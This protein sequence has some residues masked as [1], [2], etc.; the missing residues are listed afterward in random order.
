MLGF[1]LVLPHTY[2][3][4]P[5]AQGRYR[6]PR[7]PAGKYHLVAWHDTL[8]PQVRPLVVPASGDLE[9]DFQF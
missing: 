1:V 5:D 6:I 9:A 2:F 8:P 3:A 7:V 4:T